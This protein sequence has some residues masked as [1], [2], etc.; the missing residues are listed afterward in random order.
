[1][2]SWAVAKA[3]R[4]VNNIN[5]MISFI[6]ERCDAMFWESATSAACQAVFS[7]IFF[8]FLDAT[9]WRNSRNLS[10]MSS[11]EIRVLSIVS[12]DFLTYRLRSFHQQQIKNDSLSFF[13]CFS[14]IFW[15]IFRMR[16]KIRLGRICKKYSA[17]NKLGMHFIKTR[18]MRDPFLVNGYV[19]NM[20]YS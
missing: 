3:K 12:Q 8:P 17:I 11:L 15:K 16:R 19:Y 1:M 2:T 20:R 4:L 7:R 5:C 9:I 18:K 13:R 10:M 14:V 6:F